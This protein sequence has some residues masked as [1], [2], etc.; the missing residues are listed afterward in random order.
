MFKRHAWLILVV[1]MA[2][3]VFTPEA[4]A[5][6]YVRSVGRGPII[7]TGS[8]R[9]IIKSTPIVQRQNRLFHIYGNTLRRINRIRRR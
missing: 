9:Y 7:A 8:Q 3:P 1:A 6:A 4:E 2:L 5:A